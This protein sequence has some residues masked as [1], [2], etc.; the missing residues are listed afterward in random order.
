MWTGEQIWCDANDSGFMKQNGCQIVILR[1]ALIL[2][3][4]SGSLWHRFAYQGLTRCKL[5]LYVRDDSCRF[6]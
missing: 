3:V 6:F 2:R 4:V 1:M 5:I